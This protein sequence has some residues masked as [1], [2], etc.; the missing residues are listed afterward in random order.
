[1]EPSF[2]LAAAHGGVTVTLI[3]AENGP[4]YRGH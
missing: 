1:M 4:L 3:G 2:A